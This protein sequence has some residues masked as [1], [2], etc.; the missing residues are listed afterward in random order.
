[1]G[2]G[3]RLEG[4]PAVELWQLLVRADGIV[5][6]LRRAAPVEREVAPVTPRTGPTLPPDLPAPPRR[7]LLDA[8]SVPV[9]LLSLGGLCLVAF[10]A[11]F[12]AVA[13][14]VIGL[15]GRTLVMLG[16]TAVVAGAA[17]VLTRRGL[18]AS[19]E[20]LSRQR[21][22]TCQTCQLSGS[23]PSGEGSL[24]RTEV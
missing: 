17:V 11:V 1:M 24:L 14:D 15:A 23:R 18:R 7:G 13:W 12:L 8:A 4:P 10:A 6:S 21:E 5:E 3:L 2:P 9:V 19:A 22:Q 16:L 20:T